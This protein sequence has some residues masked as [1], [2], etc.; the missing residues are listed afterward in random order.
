MRTRILIGVIVM[1]SIIVIIGSVFAGRNKSTSVEN[2]TQEKMPGFT[3]ITCIQGASFF[4]NSQFTEKATAIT[5]VSDNITFQRNQYYSYK[6]GEDRYLLF[7]MEQL[8]VAAQKGTD[9]WIGDSNDKEHSLLNTNMMNIWFTQ[10]S[11]KFDSTTISNGVTV[12]VA[13]A[14]VSINSTTYGDFCGK[15]VNINKDGEEWSL[16][17]G[18][19]G[20]RFDKLSDNSKKGIET[21]CST[22]SFSNSAD[23][24]AQDIYAV[25][26]DGDNTKEKVDTTEEIFEYD[27]ASLNLSNQKNVADKD[28]EKA[29]TSTPYSML[30]LGDNGLLSAFND[31]TIHYEDAI[32]KPTHVYR[33]EE[34]KEIIKDFCMTSEQYEYN[35]CPAGS[36]WEVL[37]YDLNYKNCENEDY[38]NIQIKG[39]DGEELRYRGIK[40]TSR[41]YDMV[42]KTEEDGDW[43]RHYYTYYAVPNGCSE[44]CIE[45]GERE[46]VNGEEVSA[47]YYHIWNTNSVHGEQISVS[48][49][50][51]SGNSVSENS[52]SG[53][54]ISGNTVSENSVS[55]NSV[56]ENSVSENQA[57]EEGAPMAESNDTEEKKDDKKD[58]KAK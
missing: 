56:S 39:L 17:V 47:A 9:F 38:V 7:N 14:G 42:Y 5:Q 52:V 26:L 50:S 51:V 24:L 53:N 46:S 10:G 25:S 57:D 28:E 58:K 41:T 11:K 1:V 33:D 32:I 21:I 16:F 22:F 40:Y 55:D 31:N 4:V 29:Y 30:I 12:T 44:Y 35:E 34:A 27:E 48:E 19:P 20:E 37:E 18:V 2:L 49:N 8:I 3:E 15:L 45:A 6:N 23:L 13:T 54:S 36:S 43:I